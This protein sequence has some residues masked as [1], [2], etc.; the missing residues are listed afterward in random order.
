[1]NIIDHNNM[2]VAR[3]TVNGE[4]RTIGVF[5]YHKDPEAMTVM[6]GTLLCMPHVDNFET[7]LALLLFLRNQ[8]PR[9][10]GWSL[11]TEPGSCESRPVWQ[12]WIDRAK[13]MGHDPYDEIGDL[14]DLT[15]QATHDWPLGPAVMALDWTNKEFPA[16]A[17]IRVLL[18]QIDAGIDAE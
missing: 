7:G 9:E 10:D 4:E 12:V 16:T 15:I 3:D 11:I 18:D 14:T 6:T 8:F 2:A 13:E 17:Q 5:E 1:M